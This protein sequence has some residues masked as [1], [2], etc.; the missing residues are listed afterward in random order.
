MKINWK[1]RVKN[2]AFWLAIV[3]AILLLIS[4]ILELFGITINLDSIGTQLQS[5]IVS[6]FTILA[7]MGIVVDPTTDGVNDSDLAMIY[8]YEN[9]HP[10][11]S[12]M[13]AG[14]EE[15]EA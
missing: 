7:I 2:K 1:I 12:T 8:G 11:I 5:I 15:E 14:E 6:I 9:K 13:G 3:P 4:Q 10:E